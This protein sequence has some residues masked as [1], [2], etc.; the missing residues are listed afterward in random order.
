[1]AMEGPDYNATANLVSQYEW[2]VIGYA[3]QYLCA[4]GWFDS[5]RPAIGGRRRTD[6]LDYLPRAEGVTW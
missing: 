2:H 5:I 4:H 1:M 3:Q 6:T